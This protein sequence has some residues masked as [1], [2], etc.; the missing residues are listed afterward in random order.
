MALPAPARNTVP[1]TGITA[2]ILR[3]RCLLTLRVFWSRPY[4]IIRPPLRTPARW[5][6]KRDRRNA[7]LPHTWP[8]SARQWI[9][10][11]DQSGR[12]NLP[13]LQGEYEQRRHTYTLNSMRQAWAAR[14]AL[15]AIEVWVLVAC[16]TAEH[17]RAP[18][19]LIASTAQHHSACQH[20]TPA[21]KP[22]PQYT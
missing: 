2:H 17:S 13:E 11:S 15:L 6:T 12:Q 20:L 4:I 16:V 1:A 14:Q 9:A 5:S 21:T 8:V 18:N 19:A 7:R 3:K 22:P 10:A